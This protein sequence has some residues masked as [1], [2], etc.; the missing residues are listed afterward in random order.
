MKNLS[1]LTKFQAD[2]RV[3]L[4]YVELCWHMNYNTGPWS[5]IDLHLRPVH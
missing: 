5:L 2:C 3:A 1:L 4:L